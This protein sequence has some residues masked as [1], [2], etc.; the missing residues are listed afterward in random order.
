MAQAAQQINPSKLQIGDSAPDFALPATGGKNISL[1]DFKGKKLLVYFYPKD[2]TP[3]CTKQACSL[4]ESLQPLNKLSVVVV[5]VSK[6]SAASHEKFTK[7]FNL[8]FPLLSDKDG[9]MCERYS[10]WGE[11]TFMGK[12]YMGIE[13]SCFL[14][15]E[16]GKVAAVQYGIKPDE[17]VAW[18]MAA[19]K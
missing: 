16:N 17:Q 18:V 19:A 2:D 10:V 4:N 3:G 6:D 11:R 14:I 1:S 9:D 15:D 5:G 12:K 13:R 8:D 7:K